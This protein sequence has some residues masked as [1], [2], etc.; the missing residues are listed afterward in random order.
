MGILVERGRGGLEQSF[1]AAYEWYTKAA[2]QGDAEAQC[3]LGKILRTGRGSVS[4][5]Y[6]MA[7][8]WYHRAAEQGLAKAQFNLGGMLCNGIGGPEDCAGAL[9]WFRR[10]AQQGYPGATKHIQAIERTTMLASMP[11]I[12][13]NAPAQEDPPPPPP[14]LSPPTPLPTTVALETKRSVEL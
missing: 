2:N 12:D 7:R 11:P 1:S 5:D 3:A 14:P 6:S 13:T 4:A 10:A 8:E 9:V